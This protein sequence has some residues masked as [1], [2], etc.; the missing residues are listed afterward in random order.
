M[1][2]SQILIPKDKLFKKDIPVYKAPTNV[3]PGEGSDHIGSIVW[4]LI[5]YCKR[6]FPRFEPV[7]LR[8]HNN[9]F[10][11]ALPSKDKLFK[12]NKNFD[13]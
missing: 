4:N 11:I 2:Y 10:T 12:R 3:G 5:L 13:N 6:L 1:D 8:S 7:T 9:N